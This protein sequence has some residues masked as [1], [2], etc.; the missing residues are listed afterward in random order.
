[1][2]L[3]LTT[4]YQNKFLVTKV[5]ILSFC[6]VLFLFMC[7]NSLPATP[8]NKTSFFRVLWKEKGESTGV[9]GSTVQLSV[10][11]SCA[12]SFPSEKDNFR[13]T[14]KKKMEYKQKT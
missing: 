5:I 12:L 3:V 13:R 1:M 2:Y 14:D 9:R 11:D 7:S 8:S 10:C 4:L 6:F